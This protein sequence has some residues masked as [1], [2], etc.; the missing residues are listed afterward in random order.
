M[1]NKKSNTDQLHDA[2]I[3]NKEELDDDH[4]KAVDSLSQEEVE[5]LKSID[6]NMKKV[7]SSVGVFL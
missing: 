5:H 3:I 6:K 2:G 7:N 4:K 1:T